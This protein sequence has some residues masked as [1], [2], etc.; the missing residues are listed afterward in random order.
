MIRYAF[1]GPMASGKTTSALKLIE[2]FPDVEKLSFAAPVKEIATDH[3]GMTTKDRSLLQ[4]I[5]MT[6]RILDPETW[7]NKLI[8]R[9]EPNKSYV[10]DDVRFPNEWLALRNLGFITV[11]LDVSKEERVR[12]LKATYGEEQAKHHIEN[13]ETISEHS[14]NSVMADVI[15]RNVDEQI[16][17]IKTYLKND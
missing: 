9:I 6:G 14:V 17:E 4:I 12:R 8:S 10:V 1:L 16:E 3:F 2:A 5:G 11:W 7:V 15:W 13:M